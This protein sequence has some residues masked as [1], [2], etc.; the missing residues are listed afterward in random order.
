[1][2]HIAQQLYCLPYG[3]D[4]H[5]LKA[6]WLSM[7]AEIGSIRRL[8]GYHI[9][10]LEYSRDAQAPVLMTIE[11]LTAAIHFGL[12]NPDVP[13]SQRWPRKGCNSFHA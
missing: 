10:A 3:Q 12:F 5:S 8:A 1:M 6:T 11:A 4:T 13:R 9:L 7:L 2:I